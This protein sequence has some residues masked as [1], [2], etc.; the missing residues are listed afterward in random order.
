MRTLRTVTAGNQN[1]SSLP[2][3]AHRQ[4]MLASPRNKHRLRPLSPL[5]LVFDNSSSPPFH[6]PHSSSCPRPTAETKSAAKITGAPLLPGF[7]RSGDFRKRRLISL[8]EFSDNPEAR[9]FQEK[10][11]NRPKTGIATIT[12]RDGRLRPSSEHRERTV[13][14]ITTEHRGRAALQRGATSKSCGL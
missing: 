8:L 2:R 11:R 7:G 3:L 13:T 5:F 9:K 12:C 14:H 4:S 6:P 10:C 1:C